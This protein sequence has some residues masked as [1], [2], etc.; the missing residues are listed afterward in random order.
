MMVVFC[1]GHMHV[2]RA[3]SLF[4]NLPYE[5]CLFV[6]RFTRGQVHGR[7]GAKKLEATLR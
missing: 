2:L 5:L 1:H 7:A 6:I 4:A 3:L